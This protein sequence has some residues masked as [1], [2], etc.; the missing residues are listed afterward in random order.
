[1]SGWPAALLNL[2][3]LHGRWPLSLVRKKGQ[4]VFV[5]SIDFRSINDHM[6]KDAY[7]LPCIE[8]NLHKLA[9]AKIFSSLDSARA[10]H[11]LTISPA[12]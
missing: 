8:T 4:V 12:S 7:P 2:L 6:I 3:S 1:M 9:G 11:S 10:F 5:G